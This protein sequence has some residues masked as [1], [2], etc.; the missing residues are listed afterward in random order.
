MTV[1]Y[2]LK[3]LEKYMSSTVAGSLTNHPI[4]SLKGIGP[5][6]AEN[7]ARLE[8]N[9]IQDLLFH[10]PNR[11]EDRT[12]ITPIGTLHPGVHVLVE[13]TVQS[14]S[15]SG[16]RKVHLL[17]RIHDGT[18]AVLLRFFH[19]NAEQRNRLQPGI[20]LR[21]FVTAPLHLNRLQ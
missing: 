2:A 15:L 11:Y 21:C 9:T 1:W 8:I 12:R 10:L 18:G 20:Q 14:V 19:F 16:H 3:V 4:S 6:T 13:G 7:L 17:C 5:R